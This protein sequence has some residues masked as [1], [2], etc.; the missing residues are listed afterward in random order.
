M[1][2]VAKL[3]APNGIIFREWRTDRPALA[4]TAERNFPP[5][6]W[7]QISPLREG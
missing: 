5:G 4:L 3:T 6:Y 1:T 2:Y 7:V